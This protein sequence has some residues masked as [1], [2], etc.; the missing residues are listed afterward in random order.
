MVRVPVASVAYPVQLMTCRTGYHPCGNS[1]MTDTAWL[2]ITEK[3]SRDALPF[4]K[5]N[6]TLSWPSFPF[7]PGKLYIITP[8][9]EGCPSRRETFG[10]YVQNIEF[11]LKF[12]AELP[13]RVVNSWMVSVNIL[14]ETASVSIIYSISET[15]RFMTLVW[16]FTYVFL[17]N[18][19]IP[20]V[21]RGVFFFF[22]R[23]DR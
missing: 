20:W 15:W 10:K 22:S 14:R 2:F 19:V 13:E 9:P 6:T 5:E 16:K 17:S 23:F 3:S 4:T 12:L 18:N 11:L 1:I 21:V 8:A 7:V